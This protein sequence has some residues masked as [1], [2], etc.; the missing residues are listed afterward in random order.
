MKSYIIPIMCCF[1]L[2]A[3]ESNPTNKK[4][5]TDPSYIQEIDDWHK[6]RAERL[7]SSS[8]W[9]SLAGLFWLKEGE[10]TFGAAKDNQIVFP[11]KAPAHIGVLTLVKDSVL[12][13]INQ[14]ISLTTDSGD[15]ILRNG[16]VYYPQLGKATTMEHQTLTWAII[17]RGKRIGIRLKDSENP[18]IKAFTH[19]D[20][21]PVEKAW[22]VEGEFAPFEQA[23]NIPIENIIG[24]T[25]A[26]ESVG[27]LKFS[28]DGKALTLDVLD[29]GEEDFFM[30]FRDET[31]GES[32]YGGGRYM[33]VPKPKKDNK[34]FLDFNKAY[35]PP[36]T[37]TAYATCPLPPPQNFLEVAITAGEKTYGVH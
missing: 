10:N 21:F 28:I 27:Q 33:Y 30:I 7:T 36:C 34:V 22:Q 4:A 12:L 3:C 5:P 9:L 19:I 23:K 2:I 14:D 6:K 16:T 20:R 17:K 8:S 35:N 13:K 15:S 32:T 18:A 1:F 29:G 24:M 25:N 26:E 31:T 37:F 11:E